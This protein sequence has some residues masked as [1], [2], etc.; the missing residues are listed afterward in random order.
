LL[1][2]IHGKARLPIRRHVSVAGFALGLVRS[3]PPNVELDV[4]NVCDIF[5]N[6][7]PFFEQNRVWAGQSIEECVDL[8]EDI[9]L[10]YRTAS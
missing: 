9:V 2:V 3:A 8:F 10:V 5:H 6:V 7:W 1:N 4:Q